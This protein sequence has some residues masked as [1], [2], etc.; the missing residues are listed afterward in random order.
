MTTQPTTIWISWRVVIIMARQRGTRNLKNK[1]TKIK[2]K[3]KHFKKFWI[4]LYFFTSRQKK[5]KNMKLKF[6]KCQKVWE[7][8]Y[9]H[10]SNLKKVRE[11]QITLILIDDSFIFC[12]LVHFQ[13]KCRYHNYHIVL[14]MNE[15]SLASISW[16][17]TMSCMEDFLFFAFLFH[18]QKCC[19]SNV[20]VQKQ[21]KDHAHHV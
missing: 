10:F 19:R 4:S 1:G 20:F 11:I 8:Y 2:L 18:L 9:W 14:K 13:Y 7:K 16:A 17:L 5:W 21:C 6:F 12:A 3:H 15:R